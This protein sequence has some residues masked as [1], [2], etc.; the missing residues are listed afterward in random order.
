MKMKLEDD[1]IFVIEADEKQA[2]LM[3]HWGM[4]LNRKLAMWSGIVSVELLNRLSTLVPL[5]GP[6]EKERRRMI[7]V[8]EAVNR[9]RTF[10]PESLTPLA[11]YPVKKSLYA[12]QVRAANMALL[13]FGIIDP[14]EGGHGDR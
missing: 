11:E 10:P 3:K 1:K 12:H 2:S 8:G 6:I 7:R 9:E 5:P 14:K 4:R 13:T